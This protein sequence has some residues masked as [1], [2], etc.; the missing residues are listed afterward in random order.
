MQKNNNKKILP[1]TYYPLSTSKG[2]ATLVSILV[3]GAIGLSVVTSL[4]LL[5][6]NSSRTS[7]AIEQGNQAKSLANACAEEAL[8][9]IWNLDTFSGTGNLTFG[10]GSCS[11]VVTS[12]VVPK[13]IVATGTVDTTVRRVSIIVDSL[14]PY[15]HTLSWQEIAN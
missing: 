1:T 4:I 7:F 10:Q 6:A 9:Q 5:G 8:Q 11:F 12:D 13:T 2:Y 14:H 3:I 15:V